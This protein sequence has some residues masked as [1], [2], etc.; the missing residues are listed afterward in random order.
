MAKL[1]V[2]DTAPSFT[3]TAA[4]ESTV[5]L[6]DLAGRR[7]IVYF[8]PAAMTPGCTKQACDFRDS[9]DALQAEGFAVVGISPD[10]PAKLAKFV[11]R[12][13]ITFPLLS[14]PGH[15]VLESYG[16]WGEKSLYGKTVVGVIRSTIVIDAEGKVELAKY[17][18]KATGHVAS[19]RKALK[20]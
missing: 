19:L 1:E 18:V 11:E 20:V 10:K 4:D 14:D 2:G 9:L 16:A 6:S 13:A 17:N 15:E 7:V 3:L 5:S 8:Y 12:D